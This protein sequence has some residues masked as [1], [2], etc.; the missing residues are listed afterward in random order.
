MKKT[1]VFFA[2]ILMSATLAFGQDAATAV[3]IFNKGVEAKAAGDL[4]QAL[5]Q[6]KQAYALA[7]D[8][9]EDVDI[10]TQC[11]N[12][13]PSLAYSIVVKSYNGGAFKDCIDQLPAVIATAKEFG[14]EETEAKAE[15]MLREA[16][17]G[18][19][20]E[21][22][23]TDVEAAKA[24]LKQLAGLGDVE[25]ANGRL[26]HILCK[27][28]TEAQKEAAALTDAAAKKA[29]FQKVY[30]L[31]TEAISYEESANA[32]KL[33]AAGARGIEKWDEALANY[34]KYLELKPDAKDVANITNMIAS[35]YEKLG[36]KAHAIEAYK[37]VVEIGN[38]KQKASAEKK[39]EKLTK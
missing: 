25:R 5:Q 13:I 9:E 8:S 35:C 20:K 10:A 26:S 16:T 23:D 31:A 6:F 29:A 28:A 3:D 34:Q 39:L 14:S 24:T 4:E 12:L 1:L 18:Y 27:E 33:L 22:E 19:A 36:D 21:L 2:T 17:F 11:K 15:N 38:E 32:V 30:N 37:K 7:K